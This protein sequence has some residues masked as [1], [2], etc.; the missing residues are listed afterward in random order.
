[1]DRISNFYQKNIAKKAS[2]DSVDVI[3]NMKEKYDLDAAPISSGRLKSTEHLCRELATEA[4]KFL[5]AVKKTEAYKNFLQ[6]VTERPETHSYTVPN[7]NGLVKIQGFLYGGHQRRLGRTRGPRSH[8]GGDGRL[9]QFQVCQL[10]GDSR[11]GKHQW[12]GTDLLRNHQ[13]RLRL[14][15]FS[16]IHNCS[17]HGR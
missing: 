11:R 5:L 4:R 17:Y 14:S 8:C 16:Q 2:N 9:P 7:L 3:K 12:N 15:G 1:M 13:S 6:E 10:P